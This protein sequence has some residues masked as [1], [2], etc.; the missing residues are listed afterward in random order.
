MSPRTIIRSVDWT[1]RP[2][3]TPGAPQLPLYE[4]QCT[5]CGASSADPVSEGQTPPPK[6]GD[7]VGPEVW[8]LVHT[9]KNPSH[10]S[11]RGVATTFM[12]V[13]PSDDSDVGDPPALS[14]EKWAAP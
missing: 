5:T 6:E 12:R 7:K 13:T 14:P 1:L 2:D 3:T 11:Y 4:T 10:R 8:A 9:G